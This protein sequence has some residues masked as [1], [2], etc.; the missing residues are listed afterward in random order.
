M[1]SGDRLLGRRGACTGPKRPLVVTD[2]GVELAGLLAEA[3]RSLKAANIGHVLFKEVAPNPPV[4]LVD[5]GGAIYGSEKCDGLIGIGGGSSL[6]TAKSIG[7][8]ASNGGSILGY[9]WADPQPI[10]ARIPPTICIPT[11]A[12]TGSEVTLWAVITDPA[13]SIKFNVGAPRGLGPGWH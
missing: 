9:E 3:V 2:P 1:A 13:R 5:R 11:T 4:S 6:D 12:G 10:R 7:V 8:V